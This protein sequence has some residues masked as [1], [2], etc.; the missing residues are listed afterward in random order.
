MRDDAI[1]RIQFLLVKSTILIVKMHL[2]FCFLIPTISN[3]IQIPHI[4]FFLEFIKKKCSRY[5]K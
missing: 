5:M 2:S 4:F 3:T 1:V